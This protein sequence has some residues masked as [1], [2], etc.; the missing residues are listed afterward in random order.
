MSAM[1]K[2]PDS[3]AEMSFC[4]S[5]TAGEVCFSDEKIDPLAAAKEERQ[6]VKHST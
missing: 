3:Y 5:D 1:E 6:G 4:W 2:R